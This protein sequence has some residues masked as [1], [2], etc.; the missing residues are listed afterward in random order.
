MPHGWP[1]YLLMIAG[2]LGLLGWVA[3]KA[4]HVATWVNQRRNRTRA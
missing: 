4:I 2:A 3:V 1:I